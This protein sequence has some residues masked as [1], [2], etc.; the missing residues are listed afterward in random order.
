MI[1]LAERMND[2]HSDSRGPLYREALRMQQQGLDVLKLNTGNPAALVSLSP[3]ASAMRSK[4]AP[5][6]PSPTVIF[7]ACRLHVKPSAPMQRA[8]VSRA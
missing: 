1:H 4:A 8:R 5:Q 2:V 6:K 7:R 3:R